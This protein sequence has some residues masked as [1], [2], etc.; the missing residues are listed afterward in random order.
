MIEASTIF[1]GPGP[2]QVYHEALKAGTFQIQHCSSCGKHVFY[3]RVVC[4][5]C[6]SPELSWVAPSGDR[7]SVV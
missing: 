7:K 5:H 2:E 1:D 4:S 6:G 3:P